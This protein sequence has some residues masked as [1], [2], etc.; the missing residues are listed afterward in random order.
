MSKEDL[1]HTLNPHGGNTPPPQVAVCDETSASQSEDNAVHPELFQGETTI[2][3]E[4]LVINPPIE[5]SPEHSLEAQDDT[6]S[7]KDNL[8]LNDIDTFDSAKSH[9]SRIR[10]PLPSTT[11]LSAAEIDEVWNSSLASTLPSSIES[12]YYVKH[13]LG[14]GRLGPLYLVEDHY[15]GGHYALRLLHPWISQPPQFCFWF[16]QAYK[17]LETLRHSNLMRVFHLERLPDSGALYYTM[18]FVNGV[19]LEELQSHQPPTHEGGRP[20]FQPEDAFSLLE[21][22]GRV[23]EYAH[24]RGVV[25]GDLRAANIMLV[26]TDEGTHLR[27]MDF[28]LTRIANVAHSPALQ[29]DRT[30]RFFYTA[31]EE[32]DTSQPLT[33]ATD[34][35][36]M[37]VLFYR[38]LTG[39]IPAGWIISPYKLEPRLPQELDEILQ[40]AMH[41]DRDQRYSSVN[42]FLDDT[43]S[44]FQ[45]HF[46]LPEEK[47]V[48]DT[49][50]DVLASLKHAQLQMVKRT[51]P[52]LAFQPPSGQPVWE[53]KPIY[54][55]E[56]EV[57]AEHHVLTDN[58][59]LIKPG[60]DTVDEEPISVDSIDLDETV[61][62]T[63]IIRHKHDSGDL[64]ATN[65]E[66]PILKSAALDYPTEEAPD[67]PPSQ[68]TSYSSLEILWESQPSQPEVPP[69]SEPLA[70]FNVGVLVNQESES[71][72]G[73]VSLD[74]L[75]QMR[76]KARQEGLDDTLAS[77]PVF[78]RN[79]FVHALDHRTQIQRALF[80]PC[81]RYLLTV[82]N[83][84]QLRLWDAVTWEVLDTYTEP[85]DAVFQLTWRSNSRQ[86]AFCSAPSIVEIWN[87][88]PFERTH[89]IEVYPEVVQLSWLSNES[90]LAI[91]CSDNA[92]RLW[93]LQSER[94]YSMFKGFR[95]NGACFDFQP[96]CALFLAAS[97]SGKIR[98]WPLSESHNA[99]MLRPKPEPV[100]ALAAAESLPVMLCGNQ[101][102][103]VSVWNLSDHSQL[104]SFD[105][106]THPIQSLGCNRH[107][108]IGFSLDTSGLLVVFDLKE[109]RP[110]L[111]HRLADSGESS[112]CLSPDGMFLATVKEQDVEIWSLT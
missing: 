40:K 38:L 25:H 103:A 86:V 22:I 43:R 59:G 56:N 81:N 29:A 55:F 47:S 104:F 97:G 65:P 87:I 16:A 64:K 83:N 5:S 37:G 4:P 31:P 77:V 12:R 11:P 42:E 19:T 112:A 92:V 36:S 74:A 78:G 18:E 99:T 45:A 84:L 46:G 73:L 108:T 24:R 106:Q 72:S 49:D 23:V 48:F 7:E 39:M 110:I 57:T 102:G 28:G 89:T 68:D 69:A 8:K 27:L 51:P 30:E 35:F 95:G 91:G 60:Y 53:E 90:S 17:T 41:P 6:M 21:Q 54:N 63:P 82:D 101:S 85:V 80:S 75:N 15:F 10:T 70:D 96:S 33:A 66:T 44:L 34:V 62:E 71:P 61:T 93:S 105:I 79:R 52:S 111:Q 107:G 109:G 3:M 9:T 67:P 100:T 76:K 1:E 20:A 58:Q 94:Q 2:P 26:H 88:Q 13:Q 32:Q 50:Q 14:E 98:I